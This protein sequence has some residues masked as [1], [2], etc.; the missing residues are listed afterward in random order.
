[1][2]IV[3]FFLLSISFGSLWVGIRNTDE[4]HKIA[5]IFTGSIALIWIFCLMP[6]AVKISL[7]TVLLFLLVL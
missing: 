6:V 5:A 4:I 1:M 2:S 3:D 7:L